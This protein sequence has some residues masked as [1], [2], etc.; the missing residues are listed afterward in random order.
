MLPLPLVL[1]MLGSLA[2]VNQLATMQAVSAATTAGVVQGSIAGTVAGAAATAAATNPGL[3][4]RAVVLPLR[5]LNAPFWYLLGGAAQE[6]QLRQIQAEILTSGA[7]QT[8]F[9]DAL[10]A[11]GLDFDALRVCLSP[12]YIEALRL[13]MEASGGGGIPVRNPSPPAFL[14]LGKLTDPFDEVYTILVLNEDA[15][16][17]VIVALIC[18]AGVIFLFLFMKT[19]RYLVRYGLR[20]KKAVSKVVLEEKNKQARSELDS[21][22]LLPVRGNSPPQI[23]DAETIYL[24]PKN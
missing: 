11:M 18:V 1:A 16:K 13:Q 19:V 23:V 4:A 10:K 2:A 5:V 20:A 17:V 22:Y 12:K 7:R 21:T 15:T 9:V 8:A 14:S 24:S 3:L 6:R